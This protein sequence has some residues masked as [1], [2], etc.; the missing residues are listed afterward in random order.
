MKQKTNKAPTKKEAGTGKLKIG[1]NWNA[2]TIIAL[3]QTN[4]LKA[5]AEFV[6]NSI[7]AGAKNIQIVKGKQKGQ[8]YLRIIDDGQGIDDFKYVATHIAD[9]IKRQLKK[10]GINGIQGEFGIGLLSFWTVGEELIMT[11]TGKQGEKKRMKLVKNNPGYSITPVSTLFTGSGTELLIKPILP[12]IRQLSGEKIQNYLASELR[13]RISKSGVHITIRDR[14]AR[15]ELAVK[16][17]QFTG[18]LLHNLP[19]VRSPMGEI[20]CELYISEQKP[21]NRVALYRSG[22]RVFP[23]ISVLEHFSRPPW[24][25]GYLEGLVDVSFLQLTPGTR[26]GIIF[27]DSYESMCRSLEPLEELL[28]EIIAEQEKAEEEKTSKKILHRV[29]KAIKEAFLILP[30]EEYSWLDVYAGDKASVKNGGNSLA[31]ND[32]NVIPEDNKTNENMTGLVEPGTAEHDESVQKAFFEIPGPLYRAMISPATSIIGVNEKKTF[33]LIARDRNKRL[34]DTPLSI[35]W[36]IKEGNG[37]LSKKSGEIIEF[38]APDEPGLTVLEATAVQDDI[39]ITAESVITV[40]DQIIPKKGEESTAGIK[41]G[42]PGYTFRNA[43]GELWRSRFDHDR[44]LII[45]NNGH[46]DFMFASK[47]NTRKIKYILRLFVKELIIANFPEANRHELLERMIE[48]TMY[49]EEHLK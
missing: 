45:I 4:P 16:P 46:A 43:P 28:M 26:D 14:A 7:D 22:T 11:S 23:S 33:R 27:D 25:S 3:S 42:L 37:I 49:T 8:H 31:R 34:I 20:Y 18:R 29:K 13:D 6:E 39:R 1:D 44:N 35:T 36:S 19:E 2:I 38:T 9:S 47:N 5:I 30:S 48:L 21:E 12:G 41:K 10:E 32:A 24:T 40:T 17:R 15:K